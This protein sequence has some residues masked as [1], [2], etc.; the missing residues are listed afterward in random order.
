MRRYARCRGSGGRSSGGDCEPDIYSGPSSGAVGGGFNARCCDRLC[1]IGARSLQRYAARQRLHGGR[2][3][4]ILR[5]STINGDRTGTMMIQSNRGL[6]CQGRWSYISE[7]V[8][9]GVF[10]CNNGKSGPFE[11]NGVGPVEA[12]R[13]GLGTG[14]SSSS[15]ADLAQPLT[16]PLGVC[17]RLRLTK[18][19][20]QEKGQTSEEIGPS[21]A[22]PD[23]VL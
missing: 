5:T 20:G 7:S 3:R 6:S 1:F 9:R 19:G 16:R 18:E 21:V 22:N 12:G 11:F 14:A 13:E 15:M 10:N 2:L 4:N 17:S 23:A 8:G